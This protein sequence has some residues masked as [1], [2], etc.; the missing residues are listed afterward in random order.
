M[1]T[2]S[3]LQRNLSHQKT[4]TSALGWTGLLLLY[5]T[6]MSLYP[7]LPPLLGFA[8]VKWREALEKRDFYGVF[9]WMLY[10]VV[11]ES[12]WNLP[13]YGI[14]S[15]MIVTYTLFDPKISYLLRNRT[16]IAVVSVTVFDLLYL[17]FLQIYG[18]ILHT[19]FFGY[20]PVLLAYFAADIVG[21]LLF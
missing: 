10:A 14:W 3:D 21:V 17:L 18:S 15:A 11:F 12:V 8:Y 13:L 6:L 1:H 20:D 7:L 5:P 9:A 2:F 19:A 16:L 4:L